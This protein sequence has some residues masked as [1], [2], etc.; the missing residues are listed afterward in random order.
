MPKDKMQALVA[1]LCR[2]EAQRRDALYRAA[3]LYFMPEW[4]LNQMISTKSTD[5]L[6]F[7]GLHIVTEIH[8]YDHNREGHRE[9]LK[10]YQWGEPAM[11][12]EVA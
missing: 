7:F 8:P 5:V 2:M 1:D 11:E 3:I 6:P 10:I 4:A 12:V 9:V